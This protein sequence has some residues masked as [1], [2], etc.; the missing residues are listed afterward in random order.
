MSV[1]H[2]FRNNTHLELPEYKL[3]GREA[4]AAAKM[5]SEATQRWWASIVAEKNSLSKPTFY[6]GLGKW[7]VSNVPAMGARERTPGSVKLRELGSKGFQ[8]AGDKLC[9]AVNG[10]V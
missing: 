5:F 8:K 2:R 6:L 3:T 10:V 9:W 7:T 4:A 1:V